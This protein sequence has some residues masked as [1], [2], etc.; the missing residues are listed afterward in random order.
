[1]DFDYVVIGAGSA[2]CAVAGRLSE[3]GRARVLLLEAGGSDRRLPILM[4]AATYLLAIGNPRYDWRYKAA[5][6]PTRNDRRD[7]M[8]RGKV[9]GGTSSINGMCYVRGQPEDFDVWA[10]MGCHGWD[11]A[12]VLPYYKRAEDNENGADEY[13][14]AGGPLSVSNIRS[15]HPLSEIFL[16]S[17]VNSGLPRKTD[18]NRPPQDGIGFLQA[19]QRGGWRCSAA[20]AYLWPARRR[21]NLRVATHAHVERITFTGKR[22]TG[23]EYV[24]AGRKLTAKA[25][26][27][28]VL[29][30]GALASPQIL[31]L[32]GIGPEA[33]LRTKG[34]PVL[35]DLP[36]VGENFHDHPGTSHTVWTRGKTYNVQR[37]FFQSML[38][39]AQWL[40]AGRGPGSTPD[41][42]VIGF[43]RSRAEL[44]RC[45]VQF[46][47]TPAGYDLTENGPILFDRPAAT[48]LINIH[49]PRSR[50]W[51]RLKSAD[52][53]EQPEIQPNLLGD[54][55][56]RETLI[57]GHRLM[58]R[59][60]E[61]DPM[62]RQV[63]GEFKPGSDVQTDDEW[64]A[65]VRETAMGF[66]HPAGSCKMGSDRM[67]VVDERLKLRGVEGLYVADASIMP[68][69]VSGNLNATCI[70]IGEK[71]AD[72][73]KQAS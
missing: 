28:V 19:T 52:P 49:R 61:T 11:F 35:Q 68:I 30:A 42:H 72:M 41:A 1:M 15:A 22:A 47:F 34:I 12:S 55:G 44:N 8:P 71:C 53:F 32:S 60:C 2:G 4:P 63:I 62:A 17:C 67:A 25:S 48:G 14:G 50:G 26:R 33:H 54:E 59:I 20:R 9:L 57:R 29:C 64:R 5:A 3:D 65:F 45:D 36:G 73:L 66:Y 38:Y 69:V 6:D 16:Q 43:T 23:V 58:R 31:M 21:S 40:L 51:I 7:F 37:G 70:M 46:H 24:V 39:G 18:I 56:D 13:H 10:Q 27:A